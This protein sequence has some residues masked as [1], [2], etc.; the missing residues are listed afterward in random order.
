[1][2]GKVNSYASFLR[3]GW[4]SSFVALVVIAISLPLPVFAQGPALYGQSYVR[5]G[6]AESGEVAGLVEGTVEPWAEEDIVRYQAQLDQRQRQDGPY[7]DTLAEPLAG[8]GRYHRERGEY[9]KALSLYQQAVHVV[10][11]NDGLYSERQIP[12][13]RDLLTTYRMLGDL[14]TLDERYD[15]FFRLYGAGEPPYSDLRLRAAVE[16]LRWQREALGRIRENRV[17]RML[18]L[19]ELNEAILSAAEQSLEVSLHWYTQLTMSQVHNFYLLQAEFGPE[20]YG[21]AVQSVGGLYTSQGQDLDLQQQRLDAALRVSYKRGQ[22]LLQGLLEKTIETGDD[23]ARARVHLAS[24]DWLRWN[25]RTQPATE[26]YREVISLLEDGGQHELLQQ[27][28]GNPVELPQQWSPDNFTR[29]SEVALLA[30][31]DVSSKGAARNIS[32]S[33]LDTGGENYT[34]RL[35]RKLSDTRFR[36]RFIQGEAES[37]AGISREYRLFLD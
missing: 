6:N 4:P 31:Y 5:L 10:R 34:G 25:G 1:L 3:Y 24:G 29:D 15:Y 17:R 37:A 36:P 18:E 22:Q 28:L 20:K 19:Y 12:Y 26:Q 32:V 35:R 14:E 27:W 16:Y 7:T 33:A 23:V 21:G 9:Q 30:Q 8:L 13:V 2:S 11:I